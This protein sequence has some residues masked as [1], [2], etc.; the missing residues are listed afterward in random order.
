MK[1]LIKKRIEESVKVKESL[2]KAE[3]DNI[4]KAA[5]VIIKSLKAGGKLLVFGNGGS[6]ADS[7][8]IA[9]ELVGR[10][11]KERKALAAIALTANTSTITAIA[12]DY[13]YDVVFSRQ[14]E[15]LGNPGDV[16][17]GISTS[18]NSKNVIEAFKTAKAK[19]MKRVSLTGCG[20]G[21]LREECDISIIIDSKDTPRI[22]EAHILIG[23]ILCELIE[24]EFVK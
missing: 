12:N 14:I 18:G 6:A 17:L 13:G 9:A 19:G 16:A 8:H 5:L 24:E 22:Q 4:E 23:H 7:Q 11:K 1:E 20:G 10:F 21:K 15:A 2:C 3:A